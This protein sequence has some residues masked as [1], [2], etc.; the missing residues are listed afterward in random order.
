MWVIMLKALCEHLGFSWVVIGKEYCEHFSF[1]IRWSK[2]EVNV[3]F[4]CTNSFASKLRTKDADEVYFEYKDPIEHFLK[5]KE[6]LEGSVK[7]VHNYKF[8]KLEEMI[9]FCNLYNIK[10]SIYS[11]RETKP[12]D[13]DQLR[14]G[15]Y[16]LGDVYWQIKTRDEVNFHLEDKHKYCLDNVSF[17][18]ARYSFS[19]IDQA[20]DYLYAIL[21]R[22]SG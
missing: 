7:Y 3:V 17:P 19:N 11:D 9:A 10:W 4:D 8:S 16:V 13:I 22:V 21:P 5:C 20:K 15:E 14:D 12:I 1:D 18:P 6:L 2:G